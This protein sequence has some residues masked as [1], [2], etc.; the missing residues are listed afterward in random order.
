VPDP[1][2]AS[3]VVPTR[4]RPAYLDVALSSV[5][6]QASAAS[7]EV[8]VV[9]DGQQDA[10][11]AIANRH[12]ARLLTSPPPGG[13]NRARNAGIA[14]AR[15]DLIV[16]IDDDV[17]APQG[18]LDAILSGAASAPHVDVFGGP[19]RATLEGGGP[20]SCGR[21]NPPITTLD[22]G[23]EDRDVDLV[24][25]ANMALRRRA[26]QRAGLF[27]ESL[28]GPGDEEDWEH[29]YAAAGGV[30]RYLAGAGLEHRRTASD[31]TL[32]SLSRA[33]YRQGRA[34]RRYDSRKGLAPSLLTELRTLAGCTWHIVRRRCANG[35]VLSAHSAGRLREAVAATLNRGAAVNLGQTPDD[36]FSGTSGQVWGIRATTR[37]ALADAVCD[38]AAAATLAP[39]RLRRA[40]SAWPSR[41]VLAVGVERRDVPNVLAAARTELQRSHHDVEFVATT[42]GTKGKFE[43]LNDLLAAHPASGH[44]WLLLVDDDVGL[45]RG[46]LDVFLFLAERLD[47]AVAQPAHRW[48]SHA[49]WAVT[50]RRPGVLA[51][52]TRFVEIGPVCALRSV[53]FEALLPFPP[54]RF[55]WGLDLHWSALARERGWR[56]GVVDATPVRHGL[57]R[58]AT[59][60]DR[61]DAVAETRTF[62][63]ERPYTTATEAQ[64]TL[65]V[66]RRW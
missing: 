40:A 2:T 37:A 17:A 18:W 51:R 43:N 28:S 34:A 41:R 30:V 32:R 19:I 38:A 6:P 50:R 10:T 47:L 31:A 27:D 55:G 22:L 5:A 61:N 56:Q 60:Y 58:I 42:A 64:R 29:R 13:L 33:A 53:T 48:R 12:G 66:H 59:S 24:W 9:N 35:F 4:D 8:I 21:E 20:Q 52:Q 46:F 45:P 44:D 54:L 3:I 14:A 57:R 65:A 16:L 11:A 25:G 26:F 15:S 62:L 23:D 63:A 1:P 39:W 7:A 36:F 49:A